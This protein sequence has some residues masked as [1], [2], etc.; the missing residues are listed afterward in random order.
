M[1]G[2]DADFV[3][4]NPNGRTVVR[5]ERLHSAA[6]WSPFDGAT[7]RGRIEAS[8]LRGRLIARDDT[9]LGPPGWGRFLA[10]GER[11]AVAMPGVLQAAPA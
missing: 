11:H 7:L 8:Y 5:G 1:V 2:A 9:V 4:W 6:R 10:P 3:V